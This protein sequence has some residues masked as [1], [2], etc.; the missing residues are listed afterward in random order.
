[1]RGKHALQGPKS[2][3]DADLFGETADARAEFHRLLST[4]GQGKKTRK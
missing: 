4:A 1:V 2:T 3:E